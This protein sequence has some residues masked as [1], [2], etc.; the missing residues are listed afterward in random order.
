MGDGFYE[1]LFAQAVCGDRKVI[2]SNVTG[3]WFL[4]FRFQEDSSLQTGIKDVSE[5]KLSSKLM[6]QFV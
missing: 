5:Y 6:S 1:G 2:H 4:T 3:K